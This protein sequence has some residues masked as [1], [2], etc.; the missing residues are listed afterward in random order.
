MWPGG[1]HAARLTPL[2]TSDT[3]GASGDP[4]F[5]PQFIDVDEIPEPTFRQTET[6]V[7]NPGGP[8]MHID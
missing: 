4:A 2:I 1:Q 7:P 8:T 3:H 6:E 5:A